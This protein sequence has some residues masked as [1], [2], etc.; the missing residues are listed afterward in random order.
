VNDILKQRLVGALI[1]LAL[2][3][4]FWPIIF[5]GPDEKSVAELQSIPPPPGVST[6]SIEP[7]EQGSLR[8]SPEMATDDDSPLLEASPPSDGPG[9]ESSNEGHTAPPPA[10]PAAETTGEPAESSDTNSPGGEVR[11]EAPQRLAMDADGVPVAWTLQVATVSSAEKAE[12]LRKRLLEL[13]HK[14]Y[15]SRV[16][17]GGKSLY[18]ISIGPKFERAELERIQAGINAEF[19]VTSIVARYTP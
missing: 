7:P 3:V 13:R 4:V 1:L 6:A 10:A 14:A 8:A 12:A 9:V 16:S 18:R 19:G 11:S 17:S 5:V 2:G 15:I